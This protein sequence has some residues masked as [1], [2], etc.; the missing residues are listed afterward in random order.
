MKSSKAVK[1]KFTGKFAV[2]VMCQRHFVAS[3]GLSYL[4]VNAML[5]AFTTRAAAQ[6][7]NE[8]LGTPEVIVLSPTDRLQ[9]HSM[10]VVSRHFA[11]CLQVEGPKLLGGGRPSKQKIAKRNNLRV[12]N[13]AKAAGT[14]TTAF[15]PPIFAHCR[16]RA[17][18]ARGC[19]C[20]SEGMSSP[21][22]L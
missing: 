3:T 12:A 13:D 22:A 16:C 1:T 10:P 17:A 6:R 21:L 18:R 4:H 9:R 14:S 20:Q 11:V 7:Q 5:Q 19:S 15:R 2:L 8:M